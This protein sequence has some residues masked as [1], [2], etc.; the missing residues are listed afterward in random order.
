[1]STLEIVRRFT[2]TNTNTRVTQF[3]RRRRRYYARERSE[4]I[5]A[6]MI[7]TTGG[8]DGYKSPETAEV[9]P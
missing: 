9:G 8:K 7:E 4:L 2:H 5:E 6:V 3:E 1:M